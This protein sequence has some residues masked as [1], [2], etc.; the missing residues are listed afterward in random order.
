M[1]KLVDIQNYIEQG[2]WNET[3]PQTDSRT[4]MVSGLINQRRRFSQQYIAIAVHLL[5]THSEWIEFQFRLKTL[6]HAFN[7]WL[8][9]RSGD[10][11][12][13]RIT[14]AISVDWI[15][16]DTGGYHRKVTFTMERLA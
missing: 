11:F 16:L 12:S 1:T 10:T 5:L 7:D 4:E 6:G 9:P 13:C 8:D 2:S 14:S 3:I 15:K